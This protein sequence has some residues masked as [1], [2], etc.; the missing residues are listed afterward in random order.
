M[1]WKP[2][3][4]SPII[5]TRQGINII[6]TSRFI[7]M[8][9]K[10][11]KK[12]NQPSPGMLQATSHGL[13]RTAWEPKSNLVKLVNPYQPK[14]ING[15]DPV[16]ARVPFLTRLWCRELF[17]FVSPILTFHKIDLSLDKAINTVTNVHTLKYEQ[18]IICQLFGNLVLVNL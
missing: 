5:N 17:A 1:P 15:R 4:W 8:I 18:R 3:N 11:N 6:A 10:A 12:L 13:L 7:K 2:P 9:R 14:G 16:L